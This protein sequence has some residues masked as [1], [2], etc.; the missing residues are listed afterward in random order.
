M[1]KGTEPE[2]R[3][4][5]ATVAKYHKKATTREMG[6]YEKTFPE[7]LRAYRN[8]LRDL[9]FFLFQAASAATATAA[10]ASSFIEIRELT[11]RRANEQDEAADYRAVKRRPRVS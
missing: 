4:V 8:S 6:C 9:S 11:E 7:S 2:K 3:F 5:S 10:A 1:R